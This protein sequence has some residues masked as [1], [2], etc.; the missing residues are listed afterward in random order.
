MFHIHVCNDVWET[1]WLWPCIVEKFTSAG[2]IGGVQTQLKELHYLIRIKVSSV[3]PAVVLFQPLPDD[4]SR[5]LCGMLV[6]G[7]TD[8]KGYKFLGRVYLQTLDLLN[9]INAVLDMVFRFSYEWTDH[10]C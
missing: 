4:P 9:K 1:P 5:F 2:E 6:K 3:L 8:I 10:L 7:G